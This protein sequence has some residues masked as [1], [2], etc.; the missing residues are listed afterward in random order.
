M[1]DLTLHNLNILLHSLT[2]KYTKLKLTEAALFL[3]KKA[4]YG[5]YYF[6]IHPWFAYFRTKVETHT[7]W[8][9]EVEIRVSLL[10]ILP[11]VCNVLVRN[12]L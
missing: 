2:I 7:Y 3:E 6:I 4:G 12:N 9:K 1:V 11:S 5:N 10:N 8:Y